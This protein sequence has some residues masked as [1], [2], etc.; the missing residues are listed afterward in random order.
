MPASL[1]ETVLSPAETEAFH[2]DGY[3][4]ARGLFTPNEVWALTDHFMRL[5]ATRALK[6]YPFHGW[7]EAQ[8]DI[9]KV[10]T[11]VMQP[12]RWDD[13]S[14]KMLLEPRVAEMLRALLNEEPIAT[15]SMFYY[16]PP[17]SKGQTFHQDNYYLRVRP[18]S[19][20]ASWLAL[21]RSDLENGGLQVVPGTHTMEIACP[22][23]A[24]PKYNFSQDYVPPPPGMTPIP[25]I[26]EPGDVLFFNGSLLHGSTPNESKTR[27]RRSYICHYAP[28]SCH[29]VSKGYFPLLDMNGNVVQRE[30]A[31]GGGPCGGADKM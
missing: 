22:Q 27:W 9:L 7:E 1:C 3:H 19:C 23:K 6:H 21:D 17:G 26:L 16:K 4:I 15:Q 8:G 12:H 20:I 29:E 2:R 24:D 10:Y 18:H 14:L 30:A 28:A 13:L 11:R 5:H 25:A 31:I